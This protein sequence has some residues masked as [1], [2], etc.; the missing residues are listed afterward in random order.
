MTLLVKDHK[1]WSLIPKTRSVMGGNEGG[2]SGISEFLSLVLEPVAR[3]QDNSM[4]INATNGLLA[5]IFDLNAELENET[6]EVTS[7]EEDWPD[8]SD[9]LSSHEEEVQAGDMEDAISMEGESSI[10]T[11]KDVDHTARGGADWTL[12]LAVPVQTQ[13]DI[14]QYLKDGLSMGSF[15]KVVQRKV[16]E[17]PIDKI[18][19]IRNKLAESRRAA[20]RDN[21]KMTK[22]KDP[23]KKTMEGE[24]MIFAKDVENAKVQ[25][26]MELVVVGA[27]VEALYPNLVDIEIANIC[28]DAVIKSK[29]KFFNIN[30]RKALLYLAINMNKTDQRTS[31]L[32]RVL[33][34]RTSKAGVRPGVTS[35]PEN[36]EHWYF[37][38]REMTSSE[39]RMVVAMVI[40]VGILIM[41]NTHVY[42]WN[43]K[44]FLQKAGGPIGLRSTCAKA[45]VVMNEWDA[46]WQ[47]LCVRNNIIL[48]KGDR[49]MDDIRAF[50]TALRMG[51]RWV[52]GHL[53]FT[54]TWEEEDKKSGLSASRRTALVL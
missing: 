14:R 36:E 32:W 34:R 31:P 48:R 27:D 43:G 18:R 52:D 22:V 42:S 1:S 47:E 33:P 41:M 20:E 46:R 15:E 30:Y 38:P 2:N 21:N 37:P 23:A 35:S 11:P 28:Y 6:V 49:Y 5:D 13:A 4:E 50:L 39:K 17:E 12:P 51:W 45:G 3:E 25:D 10:R 53:C 16:E 54:K 19:M 40:K 24:R 7:H 44:S 9:E 29:I 26:P 8:H